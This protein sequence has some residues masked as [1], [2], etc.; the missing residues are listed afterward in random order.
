MMLRNK[1]VVKKGVFESVAYS[2]AK[3]HVCDRGELI[4]TSKN[5]EIICR[6]NWTKIFSVREIRV[7][8]FNDNL[9][10]YDFWY[11][12]LLFKLI[13]DDAEEWAKT[14]QNM[15]SKYVQNWMKWIEEA[16]RKRTEELKKLFDMPPKTLKRLYDD[17]RKERMQFRM[18]NIQFNVEIQR[19]AENLRGRKLK[20][21]IV[22]HS[23]VAWYEWTKGMLNKIYKARL[24]KGPK[25][26][27]ELIRFLRDYPSL[28][29]LDTEEWEIRANQVRNC[30]AHEKFY[31]D[32]KS[33]S[34]VF[35]VGKKEKRIRLREFK[36]KFN[37]LLHTNV[38]LLD[39][40]KEKVAKGEISDK[41]YL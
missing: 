16:G 30:V 38:E 29:V 28:R 35:I 32:Y 8:V 4:L 24:G 36:A 2:R 10:V 18:R 11:G 22:A 14:I 19:L 17:T 7:E 3:R 27:E 34:L 41:N 25:N 9:E 33:S 13:M 31:Y 20:A 40:L 5:L 37:S 26:D 39:C 12:R 23:Y 15:S 6:G 21:F 1:K